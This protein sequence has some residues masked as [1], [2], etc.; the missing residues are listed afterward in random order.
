M[1]GSDRFEPAGT[2]IDKAMTV[3]LVFLAQ[4][5]RCVAAV[6]LQKNW[7]KLRLLK[8]LKDLSYE[9]QKWDVKAS[10]ER[11]EE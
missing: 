1:I 4:G 7:K 6:N 10:K 9:S 5:R 2:G 11:Q 8:E 3:K